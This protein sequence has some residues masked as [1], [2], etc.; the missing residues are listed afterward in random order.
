M[1]EEHSIVGGL[2]SAVTEIVC[3]AGGGRVLRIGIRDRFSHHCGSYDYLLGEHGLDI[4]S[5]RE[6]IDAF[7]ARA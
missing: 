4:D 3:E 7:T 5:I 1:L 2:G 6:R